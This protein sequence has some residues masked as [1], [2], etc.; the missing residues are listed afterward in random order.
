MNEYRHHVSGFF[1][2]REAADRAYSKIVERGLPR[3]R[4]YIFENDAPPAVPGPQADSK[5]VR[6]EVITDGAIGTAVGVGIGAIGEVALVAANVSLF[7]ASPLLAP[8]MMM[9]WGASV[10][11]LI[12]AATG[13]RNDKDFKALVTDAVASGQIVL[14][15]ETRTKEETAIASEVIKTA[16]GDY[17]DVST[18]AA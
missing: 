9:G 18:K 15:A 13:A 17:N 6:N 11:G 7:I 10:G 2:L 8:L 12:G 5:E 4:L 16:V 3:A 14:V 1:A